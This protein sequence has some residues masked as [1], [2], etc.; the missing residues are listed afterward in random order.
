VLVRRLELAPD[1]STRSSMLWCRPTPILRGRRPRI[2]SSGGAEPG[3]LGSIHVRRTFI[4]KQPPGTL[5][6]YQRFSELLHPVIVHGKLYYPLLH[7][8]N[9]PCEYCYRIDATWN[10]RVA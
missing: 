6:R 8:L 10:V 7:E 9:D 2:R 4:F 1:A 5:F 3:T